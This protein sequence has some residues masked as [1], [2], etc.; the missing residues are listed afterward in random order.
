MFIPRFVGIRNIKFHSPLCRNT[1]Y[2]MSFPALSEHG[3]SKSSF[4]V[5]SE[6]G[7][8]K[9]I[10]R[11]IGIRSIKCHSPV[12]QNTE[13]QTSFPGLSDYG[14]GKRLSPVCRITEVHSNS[15]FSSVIPRFIGT[16]NI[17]IIIPRFIG[18]RNT[19][20]HSL[21]YRNTEYQMSFPG[22]PE[23]GISNFIPRFIGIRSIKCHSPVYRNTEYQ[24]SFPGLSDYGKEKNVFPRFAGLQKFTQIQFS[25]VSFPVCRRTKCQKCHP[26]CVWS[27]DIT[28]QNV[29]FYKPS[30][31]KYISKFPNVYSR[32]C[33]LSFIFIQLSTR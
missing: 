8:P 13:Y 3:I 10:P 23:Y 12:Y 24:T 28:N 18:I 5:L 19:K 15:V 14:K 4:P 17:K 1:E 2:Q 9:V 27:R 21:V 7:I 29:C 25:Q 20:S 26:Q 33:F 6:Y 22:L 32:F 30:V 11:F 31:Y 16:R